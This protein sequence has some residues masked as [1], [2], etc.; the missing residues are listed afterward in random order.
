TY[1][2]LSTVWGTAQPFSAGITATGSSAW[3]F[4]SGTGLF[5]TSTVVNTF[6]GSAHNFDAVL[7][8]TTNDAAALGTSALSFSDLFLASGALIN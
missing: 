2:T 3:D 5:K 4:S 1:I 7:Q 8:P 6:K